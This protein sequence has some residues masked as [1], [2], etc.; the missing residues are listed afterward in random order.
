MASNAALTFSHSAALASSSVFSSASTFPTSSF[1][2]FLTILSPSLDTSSTLLRSA[3]KKSS[4]ARNVAFEVEYASFGAV[5]DVEVESSCE[6]EGGEGR[7]TRDVEGVK[8]D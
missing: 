1:L 6:E 3:T 2:V 4:Y 7:K 5:G 8:L